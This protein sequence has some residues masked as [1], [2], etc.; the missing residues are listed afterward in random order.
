VRV[1]FQIFLVSLIVLVAGSIGVFPT[2]PAKAANDVSLSCAVGSS[3]SCP[4]QSPQEIVNLYGTSTNGTYW[5]NV[6]GTARETYVIL[7]SG[8]PDSGGW[9]LGMKGTRSGTSFTYNSTQWTDQTTTLSPSSLLDDVSTEAKFHAFNHL[10]VTKL[11]AVF[12]D[13]ASNAFNTN[14][15]GDLGTNSFGGHTWMETITASTMF[16]RFTS[17]LN[18]V[19]ASGYSG[20]F[21]LT[22]ETNSSSGKLVFPY[23][24][25]WSRYGF[26]NTDAYVYRWGLTFNNEGSNGSN[27]TGSGIG[28]STYS[29]AAQV[30]YSDNLTVGPNSG[31]GASNPGTFAY[32]SGFQ[33]WGKMAAGTLAAPTSITQSQQS[34][35]STRISWASVASANEYLVQYKTSAQSWSQGS[36]VRVT[37]PSASP[38]ALLTGLTDT[39]YN[40]RIWARGSSNTYGASSGSL[41]ATLDQT[42]P[43][44]TGPSS[45]TGANSS[46][47][48][49]ES[50]T[51]VHTFTANE[52]VTWSKSGTDE[53]FFSITSAGGVL[54]ITARD[55]ES[56]V[57]NGSNN[58]YVVIITATDSVG[59]ATNQTLTVTITNVNEAPTIT[60]ASSAATHTITQA[61]NTSSVVTY[62]GSDID[63]GTTLTWSISGT[64]A[65]DLSINSSTGVLAFV[66]NPDFEAPADADTNNSY[67]LIV[68]LSDGSL[69]DTQTVT[70]TITNANE[71]ASINAPTVSGTINKGVNT[72]I[73]VTIN[74]AGKVRFFVGNKRISTCKE[75]TTSGTYPNNTATCTWKPAVTGRQFLTATLTPTDNTF[76]SSTSARTE[77]F[78]VKRATPR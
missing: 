58:T 29:A 72:T 20:R 7:S 57:D 15:S 13:R 62:T 59:N 25:G 40:V 36:T 11:V 74:V 34:S 3:S 21:T 18:L 16:S 43:T 53:S 6:N 54:T 48:I 19:D 12:K 42:A 67:I 76:S 55:F 69:T 9:F 73:T 39:S 14:G 77:V 41:T 31:S 51:A 17:Q 23:Q 33:I 10:P 27:D 32:P 65:A 1:K 4:A 30:S 71:S 8:Y 63:A 56:P 35:S 24:T 38:S 26:N 66:T 70:I 22:R 2:Q 46:I 50:S 64:D 61:E 68:T 52:S 47:S 45:A 5:L 28:M 49:A 37:S 78:V 60:T 75:R 44:I